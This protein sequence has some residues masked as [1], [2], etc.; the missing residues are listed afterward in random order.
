MLNKLVK[1]AVDLL[2]NYQMVTT[3]NNHVVT[4]LIKLKGKNATL[5]V[6]IL[7]EHV[8]IELSHD[9]GDPKVIG[10]FKFNEFMSLTHTDLKSMLEGE[11]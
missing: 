10:E 2:K 1:K 3:W 4:C 6:R 11:R 5:D 7:D 8:S 9:Y